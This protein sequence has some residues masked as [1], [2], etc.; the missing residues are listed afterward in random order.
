MKP[1]QIP[2]AECWELGWTEI[3]GLLAARIVQLAGIETAASDSE[4]SVEYEPT[5]QAT[6]S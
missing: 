6:R 2:S 1:T 3:S 4:T 5:D